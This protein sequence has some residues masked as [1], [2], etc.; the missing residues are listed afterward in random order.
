MYTSRC[1]KKLSLSSLRNLQFNIVQKTANIQRFSQKM[2]Q[3]KSEHILEL[4]TPLE[5]L[6][7]REAFEN[8]TETEKK[9]LHFYSKVNIVQLS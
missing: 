9:Y 5:L 3:K 2:D 7:C 6:D 4:N 1:I 8:L